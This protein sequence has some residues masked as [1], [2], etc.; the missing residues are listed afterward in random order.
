MRAFSTQSKSRESFRRR[1]VFRHQ[2]ADELNH[3][4]FYIRTID[5]H[6]QARVA[7]EIIEPGMVFNESSGH[8][9]VYIGDSFVNRTLQNPQWLEPASVTTFP[10]MPGHGM[11]ETF[12]DGYGLSAG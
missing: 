2:I 7:G 11:S 4:G 6:I 10:R 3:S 5:R 8:I 1:H 9:H 12:D